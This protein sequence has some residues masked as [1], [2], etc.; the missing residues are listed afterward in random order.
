M[1]IV[2]EAGVWNG[3]SYL[4]P[5]PLWAWGSWTNAVR[6]E[7]SCGWRWKGNGTSAQAGWLESSGPREGWGC[8][9]GN[10]VSQFSIKIYIYIYIYIYTKLHLGTSMEVQWLRIH[11][12]AQE[13]SAWPGKST[14][15]AEQLSR[16]T[17][18]TSPRGNGWRLLKKRVKWANAGH[19]RT[20]LAS[21]QRKHWSREE[22]SPGKMLGGDKWAGVSQGSPGSQVCRRG[23]G[24]GH[25]QADPSLCLVLPGGPGGAFHCYA[26]KIALKKWRLCYWWTFFFFLSSDEFFNMPVISLEK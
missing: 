8:Q 26:F 4:G 6:L 17:A 11:P 13:L 18:A 5:E 23:W 3:G 10:F 7:V 1:P 19:R 21:T 22:V 9:E 14:P 16:C 15:A 2:F 25:V 12:R 24:R 20:V